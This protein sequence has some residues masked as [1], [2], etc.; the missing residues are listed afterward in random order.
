MV[1]RSKRTKRPAREHSPATIPAVR[2]TIVGTRVGPSQHGELLSQRTAPA[3][4]VTPR[5][6]IDPSCKVLQPPSVDDDEDQ[7]SLGDSMDR[8]NPLH[9]E[10]D[11]ISDPIS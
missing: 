10:I 6:R 9:Y 2:G 1:N 3:A 5:D 8:D 11:A 4:R 7:G